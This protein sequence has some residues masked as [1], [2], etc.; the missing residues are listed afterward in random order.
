MK[1][2]VLLCMAVFAMCAVSAQE[3]P[4]SKYINFSKEDFKE[5]KFKYKKRY[6]SWVL[7]K[8]DGLNETFNV[9]FIIT[10]SDEEVRPSTD[11]YTITVQMGADD[12]VS[13]ITVEFYNDA[14]YHKLL[15]FLLDNCSN[16]LETVSGK[17]TKYQASYNGYALE[18]DL[19]QNI[20]SR[21]SSRTADPRTVKNV[22]E[23]YNE[24]MFT[25]STSVPP[26]SKYLDKQAAKKAKRKAKGRKMD[27][28]DMM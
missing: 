8:V 27:L 17:H 26:Q 20:I 12:M 3:L 6:N 4:Y 14:T 1:R 11:D 13:Y 28:E 7:N 19:I 25:I 24:F 15:T 2:I 5:N 16:V 9:L 23:S 22:D 21:T 10:G 18:L